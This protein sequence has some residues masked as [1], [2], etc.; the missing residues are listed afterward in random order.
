[1]KWNPSGLRSVPGRR[2]LSF[3]VCSV[4]LGTTAVARAPY[5]SIVVFG[6]SLCDTGR[7]A[8]LT[9]GAFPAPPTYAFGRSSNGP[10]W[11]EYLADWLGMSDM[12][13]NY[14]VIGA[15]TAPAP[16][17]PT[18]NVWS[19]T[20][21]GLE[22][23]DVTSQVYDYLAGTG[24]MADPEALYIVQGGANDFP[25]VADPAVI[26]QNLAQLVG[27]LQWSGARNIMVVNLPDLGKTPRVILGEETGVLDPGTGAYVSASCA[28]LNSYL[29]GAIDAL[30]APGVTII[31]A[32]AYAFV[33][34]VA[35]TP[36]DYGMVNVQYP[37]LLFGV[38]TDPSQW[39]FWDDLHPTT[40]GHEIFAD[41]VLRTMLAAYSPR[42]AKAGPAPVQSLRGL[43]IGRPSNK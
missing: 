3:L 13:Q 33:D 2:L 31:H 10:V 17:F 22:G 4:L 24:G 20:F 1:M 37:Y 12:V 28:L 36:A 35:A 11:N 16:G 41:D 26:V 42:N 19:D 6:D 7:M 23:T 9:G 30:A 14:A 21:S 27:I 15:M 34:R 18:G 43:T 8:T 25:R 29:S 5:T 32:D 40:R 38:G 39:L